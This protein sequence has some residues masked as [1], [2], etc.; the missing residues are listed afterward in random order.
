MGVIE[1]G[2]FC[3]VAGLEVLPLGIDEEQ[4]SL[5]TIE[6]VMVFFAEVGL[7]RR[8]T[9]LLSGGGL[10]T[11]IVGT[12]CSLYRRSTSYVRLP[13]TLIGMIDASIAIVRPVIASI[14]VSLIESGAFSERNGKRPLMPIFFGDGWLTGG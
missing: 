14:L 9:P 3:T 6:D 1:A 5:K 13:T 12:A 11:D 7:M 2:K 8:E 10:I 4:K